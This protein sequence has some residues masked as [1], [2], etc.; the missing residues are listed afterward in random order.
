VI[1]PTACR[2]GES[3]PSEMTPRLPRRNPRPRKIIGKEIGARETM[4]SV[5]P[6][7]TRTKAARERSVTSCGT[8][9]F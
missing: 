5:R 3:G 8:A 9:R 2:V 4:P 1:A 6:A 7:K